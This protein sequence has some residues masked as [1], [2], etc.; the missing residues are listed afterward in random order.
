MTLTGING[1]A[2]IDTV[3]YAVMLSGILSGDGGLNKLGSG[4]LTLS[5][6]NSYK[7]NTFINTGKLTLT[8]TGS[9]G[10]TAIIDILGN[11]TFDTS[12]KNSGGGFTLN[13]G[14]TLMGGGNIIGDIIASVGSHIAPGDSAGTLTIAGNL[15]LNDGALLDFEL[16][17]ISASDKISMSSSTLFINNLDFYDFHFTALSG[18]GTG[19]YTLIDAGTISGQLGS[20]L[21]GPIGNYSGTLSKS[22]NDLI[23]TVAVPEPGTWILLASACLAI[24]A[25]KRMGI[26]DKR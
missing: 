12:A 10:S 8:S 15:T 26:R 22:N 23:L 20:K 16:G 7:G 13:S 6:A 9:I 11:A 4:M 25:G 3:G 21:T 14:Q 19:I 1:N 18:F 24:F 2:N 5:A 17:S